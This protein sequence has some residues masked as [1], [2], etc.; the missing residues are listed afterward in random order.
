MMKYTVM[1]CHTG[2]AV[3]MDEEARFVKAA[4]LHYAVG[5]T[6][7]EPVLMQEETHITMRKNVVLKIAAAAACLVMAAGIG[8]K[9]YLN[10]NNAETEG[11]SIVMVIEETQYEMQLNPSGEVIRVQ[12]PDEA[13]RAVLAK[14]N[15]KKQ[16]A[17]DAANALLKIQKSEAEM[18]DGETVE[19][20]IET[21]N[22]E[23]YESCKSDIEKGAAELHLK[24]AVQERGTAGRHEKQTK[25]AI[26]TTVTTATTEAAEQHTTAVTELPAPSEAE[27]PG[28]HNG[29]RPE[30]LRP[31]GDINTQPGPPVLTTP[32]P[33]QTLPS[34]PHTLPE[35]PLAGQNP[36]LTRPTAPVHIE[37]EKPAEGTVPTLPA[38]NDKPVLA[39]PKKDEHGKKEEHG[40]IDPLKPEEPKEIPTEEP[41]ELPTEEPGRRYHNPM[42]P[43]HPVQDMQETQEKPELSESP[44][45]PE[46]PQPGHAEG[47]GVLPH[48]QKIV[49]DAAVKP[50]EPFRSR[51][52]V[53]AEQPQAVPD[54]PAADAEAE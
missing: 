53:P 26:E 3:L 21:E 12:S 27:K 32:D 36:A 51:P 5:Q 28:L 16:T 39:D 37:P 23:V 18:Q 54:E 7:T 44:K 30:P 11:E 45:A 14:Y 9:V 31:D 8:L 40:K 22:D 24:A 4:N 52:D 19:I 1:E 17:A 13:G 6:V 46:L 20:Y 50:E 49:P 42:M 47:E 29:T 10:R 33:K 34:A 2:Y 41:K 35:P 48:E 43:Q 15:G 25:Q 38:E